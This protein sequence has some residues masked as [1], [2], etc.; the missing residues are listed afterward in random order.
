MCYF[1]SKKNIIVEDCNLLEY[2]N[3]NRRFKIKDVRVIKIYNIEYYFI[4]IYF[5]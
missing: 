5:V 4:K 3:I 1:T 2:E